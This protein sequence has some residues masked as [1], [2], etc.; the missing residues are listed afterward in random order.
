MKKYA[1]RFVGAVSIGVLALLATSLETNPRMAIAVFL[2]L[3]S[4]VLMFVGRRQLGNSF[5]VMPEA[6]AL[7]TQG[8][9]ARIQH[10]M[11]LFLDLVLVSVIVGLGYPY[12]LLV[13]AFLVV[14]QLRQGRREE[15]VL[16]SGFGAAYEAYRSQTWF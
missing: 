16:A 10:P 14:L 11:Y 13:W 3:P 12:L 5:S 8:L 2:G 1:I 4:M 7:V 6:K 15:R 9:Y